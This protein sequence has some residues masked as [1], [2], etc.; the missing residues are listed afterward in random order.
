[1]LLSI[2]DKF[3]LDSISLRVLD[4]EDDSSQY[5]SYEANLV[6]NNDKNNLHYTIEVA[7]INELGILS[8]YIYTDFNKSK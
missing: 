7:G 8:G 1:M 3:I 6:T 5:K 4:I 2:L